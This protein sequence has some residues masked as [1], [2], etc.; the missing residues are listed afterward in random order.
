MVLLEVVIVIGV[1][2]LDNGHGASR[3]RIVIMTV[4]IIIFIV[5]VM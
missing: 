2:V 1:W 4:V 3:R 5:V